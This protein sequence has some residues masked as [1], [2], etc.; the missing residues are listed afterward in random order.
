MGPSNPWVHLLTQPGMGPVR[1]D[2]GRY[3]WKYNGTKRMG[4]V[5]S[6]KKKHWDPDL[7][8]V[9]S[10]HNFLKKHFQD[11]PMFLIERLAVHAK[12]ESTKQIIRKDLF[13]SR[14]QHQKPEIKSGS[15]LEIRD[16]Q[17]PLHASDEF[18]HHFFWPLG[19]THL[20]TSLVGSLQTMTG[21]SSPLPK[22]TMVLPR[23]H[24]E[25]RVV[26]VNGEPRR[27]TH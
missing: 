13:F 25:N 10:N 15:D 1:K 2:H 17:I 3:N 23:S 20:N 7:E 14:L 6:I 22:R 18:K 19:P 5:K 12:E 4:V 27:P 24:S 11:L 21:T 26:H 9:G 16:T 8:K